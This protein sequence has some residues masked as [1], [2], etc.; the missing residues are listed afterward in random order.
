MLPLVVPGKGRRDLGCG[1]RGAVDAAVRDLPTAS[2]AG[3]RIASGATF[4]KRYPSGT[5]DRRDPL[6]GDQAVRRVVRTG[7][8]DQGTGTRRRPR[9]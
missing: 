2:A 9:R 4:K 8:E 6:G 3:F 1:V 5:L 7:W